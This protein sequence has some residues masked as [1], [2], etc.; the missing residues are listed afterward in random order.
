MTKFLMHP[1]IALHLWLI[2]TMF[3]FFLS[4]YFGMNGVLIASA[5]CIISFIV[6]C[7]CKLEE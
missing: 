7:I 5:Y 1:I 2:L 3:V 4:E 6:Y